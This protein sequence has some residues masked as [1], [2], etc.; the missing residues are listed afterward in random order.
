MW[1]LVLLLFCMPFSGSPCEFIELSQGE[2][3]KLSSVVFEGTV[4]AVHHFDTEEQ[5]KLSSRTLV[6]FSVSRRWK[7]AAESKIQIHA[8]ERGMAW[9]EQSYIFEA[10][11]RYVVYASLLDKEGGWADQ[12]PKGTKILKLRRA[13]EDPDQEAK[14]LGKAI[15]RPSTDP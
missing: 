7:G 14:R 5:R 6:T 9:C 1:R 13:A 4:T 11:R 10:G 15:R 12:Y 3:F 2:T 8:W